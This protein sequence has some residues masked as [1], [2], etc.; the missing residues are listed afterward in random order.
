MVTRALEPVIGLNCTGT[1]TV[2][3]CCL[4]SVIGREVDGLRL[5]C[6]N[7]SGSGSAPSDGRRPRPACRGGRRSPAS[8]CRT[9]ATGWRA[10]RTRCST[11]WPG[12]RRS[13]ADPRARRRRGDGTTRV[14]VTPPCVASGMSEHRVEHVVRRVGGDSRRAAAPN[15]RASGTR[16]WRIS[17][18]SSCEN[19]SGITLVRER[20]IENMS[21]WPSRARAHGVDEIGRHAARSRRRGCPATRAR[22]RA[23]RSRRSPR[24][25]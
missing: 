7:R 17:V 15:V 24:C 18:T 11:P 20:T 2:A 1:L 21:G 6:R 5:D 8:A 19:R 16:N 23:G 10:S 3:F 13:A 22:R 12:C 4:L 25:C 9:P 14:T